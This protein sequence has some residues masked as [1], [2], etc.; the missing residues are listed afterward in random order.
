MVVV[1]CKKVC[2]PIRV[3]P[4]KKGVICYEKKYMDFGGIGNYYIDRCYDSGSF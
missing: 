3:Y 1:K 2:A 4:I